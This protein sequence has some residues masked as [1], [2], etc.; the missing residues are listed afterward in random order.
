MA[1][2][3][4]KGA[5]MDILANY[6]IS[7]TERGECKCGACIDVGNKPDPQRHT[8]DMVF[9]KVARVNGAD[10]D[11]FKRLT[12]EHHGHYGEVDPFDGKEHNYME[13]GGWIGDQGLAMQ[14]MALGVLLGKFKLLSPAMLG[15]EG[16]AAL[17]LAGM[18][19]LS[20]QAEA[21]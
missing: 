2:K 1:V 14:Y 6:V 18:G 17:Q 11:E 8:V 12:T 4:R 3:E 7:H 21:S 16:P 9:F 10:A 15:M 19:L 5:T 13:L 20:I